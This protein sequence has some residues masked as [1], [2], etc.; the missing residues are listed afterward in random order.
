MYIENVFE[1]LDAPNEWFFDEVQQKLYY[2]VNG[3]DYSLEDSV[4]EITNLKELITIK[5]EM[6]NPAK[7]ITIRGLNFKDT[8]YTYMDAHE[9]PSGGDWGL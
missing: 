5:A 7:D 2:I 3:T 1:E 8:V 4:F 6:E 9:M